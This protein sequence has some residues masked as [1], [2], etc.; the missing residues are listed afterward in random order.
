M[1]A[2]LSANAAGHFVRSAAPF[3]S[4]DVFSEP[5][6]T[7]KSVSWFARDYLVLQPRMTNGGVRFPGSECGL[8]QFDA[9]DI[10]TCAKL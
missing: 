7:T 3:D 9:P 2:P 8:R 5:C 1:E 4:E 10:L 6:G